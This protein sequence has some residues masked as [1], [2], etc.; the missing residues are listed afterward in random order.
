MLTVSMDNAVAL[1]D[2]KF[3]TYIRL[4][5]Q[6][7]HSDLYPKAP[8]RSFR[9]PEEWDLDQQEF[10]RMITLTKGTFYDTERPSRP[11][12]YVVVPAEM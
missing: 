11:A 6:E 8:L 3:R 9:P 7:V 5:N 1:P 2:M 4:N 10:R 12:L